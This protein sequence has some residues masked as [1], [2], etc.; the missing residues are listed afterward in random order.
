MNHDDVFPE[1]FLN[2]ED[3]PGIHFHLVNFSGDKNEPD[4]DEL[5]GLKD[6]EASQKEFIRTPLFKKAVSILKISEAIS[7]NLVEEAKQLCFHDHL[8]QAANILFGKLMSIQVEKFYSDKMEKATV[9]KNAAKELAVIGL[10]CSHQ[11]F[12]D[13]HHLALLAEEMDEFRN[14]FNEWVKNFDSSI[15]TNDEWAIGF[16]YKK[17]QIPD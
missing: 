2:D 7:E 11:K 8:F 3:E 5:L 10:I 6:F 17:P 15:D 9:V 14:L 1:D 13:A 16:H 12:G 4:F